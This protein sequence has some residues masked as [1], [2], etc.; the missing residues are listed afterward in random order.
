[1]GKIRRDYGAMNIDYTP[2][3]KEF[4]DAVEKYKRD[5]NKKF[6]ALHE[7]L[8]I[9]ESLGYRKV[10]EPRAL[11]T[12]SELCKASRPEPRDGKDDAA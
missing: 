1:M 2:D 7:Y 11:P 4:M 8:A 3:E 6:L 10:A 12:R 5:N 9:L